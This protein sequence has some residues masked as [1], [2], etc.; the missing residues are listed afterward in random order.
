LKGLNAQ[1]HN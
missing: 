1:C